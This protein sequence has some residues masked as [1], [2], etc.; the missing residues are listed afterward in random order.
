M[1][2][3]Y[4]DLTCCHTLSG[5]LEDSC[6]SPRPWLCSWRLF[7]LGWA[8]FFF[9]LEAAADHSKLALKPPPRCPQQ[10][11]LQGP[12][13][14]CVGLWVPAGDSKPRYFLI[15]VCP[16]PPRPSGHRVQSLQDGVLRCLFPVNTDNRNRDTGA[17]QGTEFWKSPQR[18]VRWMR[19]IKGQEVGSKRCDSGFELHNADM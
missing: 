4:C 5:D 1:G 10:G 18:L 7:C 13:P 9:L 6:S 19:W 3:L 2:F 12:H 15:C 8:H 16:C 17:H 11:S 14:P